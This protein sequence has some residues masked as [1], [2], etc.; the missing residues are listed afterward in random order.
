[1]TA[2]RVSAISIPM[3]AIEERYMDEAQAQELWDQLVQISSGSSGSC[4]RLSM[5]RG[6]RLTYW[7]TN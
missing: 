3:A 5:T 4:A 1:M 6:Q 2:S 7:A